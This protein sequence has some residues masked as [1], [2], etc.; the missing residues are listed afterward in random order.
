MTSTIEKTDTEDRVEHGMAEEKNVEEIRDLGRIVIDALDFK[1]PRYVEAILGRWWTWLPP[2]RALSEFR[3]ASPWRLR[4]TLKYLIQVTIPS[5]LLEPPVDSN[6]GLFRNRTKILKEPDPE[7][8]EDSFPEETWFYVNGIVANEQL[9]R[10]QAKS[11]A[12][13]F[14]RPINIIFNA[15]DSTGADVLECVLGKGWGIMS[16]PARFAYHRLHETLEDE[17]KKRVVVVGYS[18]GTI[19]AANVLRALEDPRFRARLFESESAPEP[20]AAAGPSR[21]ELLRKLEVYAFGNCADT[22]LHDPGM[23]AAGNAVPWIESLSNEYDLFARMGVLAPH[24]KRNGIEI[25]GASYV[26]RG[27]FGHQLNEQY[28]F[29]IYDC[30]DAGRDTSYVPVEGSHELPRLFSY[31]G[32]QTPDP[33]S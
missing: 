21:P 25:Q 32:G 31:F 7:G 28:L 3:V 8:R 6:D 24:K 10:I 18:Q 20:D 13:L 12:L 15:T 33:Y 17:S 23:L 2:H 5:I 16:E 27:K 1:P 30:L 11:L 19:I 26:K 29:D 14:R 9:A 22:M 4:R